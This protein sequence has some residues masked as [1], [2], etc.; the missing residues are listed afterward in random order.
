[1]LM[2]MGRSM[3]S[4]KVRYMC[5]FPEKVGVDADMGGRV[6]KKQGGCDG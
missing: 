5:L 6:K 2:M 4:C 1:M 3:M